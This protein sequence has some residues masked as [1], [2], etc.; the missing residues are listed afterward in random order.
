MN[1]ASDKELDTVKKWVAATWDGINVLDN[2]ET[3]AA[4]AKGAIH[5]VENLTK[6]LETWMSV[7]NDTRKF[8]PTR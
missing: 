1:A 4:F 7:D 8:L 5:N 6:A 2:S 3:F